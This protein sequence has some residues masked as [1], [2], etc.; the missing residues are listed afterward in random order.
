[1][2]SVNFLVRLFMPLFESK[3]KA[4]VFGSSLALTLPSLFAKVHEIEKGS[5]MKVFFGLDGIL[6]VS[7]VDDK[8]VV[9]ESLVKL[10]DLLDESV[11]E[12]RGSE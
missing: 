12:E 8:E 1:M 7:C 5:K 9:I 6:V 3:R 4:Q 2:I 10:L 11:E